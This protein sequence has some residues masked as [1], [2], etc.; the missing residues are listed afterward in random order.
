MF[1]LGA[2][3]NGCT[4]YSPT[5]H[6]YD[7]GGYNVY[8]SMLIYYIYHGRIASL[9]RDSATKLIKTAVKS[10]PKYLRRCIK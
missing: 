2:Y 1:Y 3:T 8:W 7:K 9:N 5:Q 6:E 4:G 10:V